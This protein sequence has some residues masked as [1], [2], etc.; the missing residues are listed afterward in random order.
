MVTKR[1]TRVRVGWSSTQCRLFRYNDSTQ[2]KTYSL[3]I[4]IRP[5]LTARSFFSRYAHIIGVVVR[6]MIMDTKTAVER[7]TANSRKRRPTI[8]PISRRG[9]NTAMSE[10]LMVKTVK[11][12]SSAPLRAA[13]KGLIPSS[14]WREMFSI[15][16]MAS[17]TTNPVEM[18]M[19][20]SERLSSVY[21]NR[22]IT[23]NV[24]ISETGTATAG[25]SVARPLRRNTNTTTMT[26]AMEISNVLS[27]S[28][29][30]ARMVV[31]RSRTIVVSMPSGMDALIIG[32]CAR[33][34]ST[35]SMILAPG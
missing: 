27:T 13:A 20:M 8:P 32:S 9:I 15:T 34:R 3:A 1:T 4:Y 17:S 21:P 30:E 26:R 16:T 22:Y 24:P 14:R 25:M 7:V 6:E 28:L 19:A 35:V 23:A 12:I 29:T 33:T 10:M 18:V 11:P 2:S 5:C 31:V